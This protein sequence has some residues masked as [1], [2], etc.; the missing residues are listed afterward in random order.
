MPDY[1]LQSTTLEELTIRSCPILERRYKVEEAENWVKDCGNSKIRIY[2]DLE[3]SSPSVVSFHDCVEDELPE[4]QIAIPRYVSLFI[5]CWINL[6][7]YF[8]VIHFKL[9]LCVY[10]LDNIFQFWS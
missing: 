9:T 1:L 8:S 5:I 4:T 3:S 6:F 7:I 10:L 2:D